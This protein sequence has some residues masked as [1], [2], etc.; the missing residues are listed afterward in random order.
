M[1][2]FFNVTGV[3]RLDLRL[4]RMQTKVAKKAVK[5]GVG[6][7]LLVMKAQIK[8]NAR[9]LGRSGSGDKTAMGSLIAKATVL[10]T[11]KRQKSGMFVRGIKQ[12]F[13]P[14]FVHNTQDG[15]GYWIPFAIEFGH[16]FPGRGGGKNPPKDVRPVSF[17]RKAFVSKKRKTVKVFEQVIQREIEL[18]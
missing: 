4:S 13:M 8:K 10:H 9:A 11:P 6:K 14:E 15:K 18:T 12:K 2:Q 7:G 17:I 1:A 5:K 16:A 3:K